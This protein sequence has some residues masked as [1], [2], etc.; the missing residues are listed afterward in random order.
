MIFVCVIMLL[1]CI[2]VY[3]SLKSVYSLPTT[4][5][6]YTKISLFLV[7]GTP[8]L[9]ERE[10]VLL[11]WRNN[12]EEARTSGVAILVCNTWLVNYSLYL[13]T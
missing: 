8:F 9:V 12:R 2:S 10:H 5:Y 3:P 6:Q 1:S 4:D 13:L 7:Y 11:A